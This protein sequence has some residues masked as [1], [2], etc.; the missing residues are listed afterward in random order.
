MTVAA[1]LTGGGVMLFLAVMIIFTY[2]DFAVRPMTIGGVA[3]AVLVPV[4]AYPLTQ[5]LWSAFDLRVHPPLPREFT[6]STPTDFLPVAPI[7]AGRNDVS[8]TSMWATPPNT[9]DSTS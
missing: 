1:V 3:I 9:D 5:T 4:F 6:D 8:A 2:P 7:V